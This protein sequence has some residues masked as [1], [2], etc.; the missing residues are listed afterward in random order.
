MNII[1][2]KYTWCIKN[3]LFNS[4]SWSEKITW[5]VKTVFRCIITRN[6]SMANNKNHVCKSAS[7]HIF[8]HQPKV[9]LALTDRRSAG[10]RFIGDCIKNNIQLRS[11]QFYLYTKNISSY[12]DCAV[13]HVMSHYLFINALCVW[14]GTQESHLIDRNRNLNINSLTL[15]EDKSSSVNNITV[16]QLLFSFFYLLSVHR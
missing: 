5:T 2:I 1:K 4:F 9:Q 14:Q 15:T 16:S 10:T 3:V 7:F 12:C 11:R 8:G 13:T 6:A